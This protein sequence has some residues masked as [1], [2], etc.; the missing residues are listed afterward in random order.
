MADE[1]EWNAFADQAFIAT[2]D[3][4]LARTAAGAGV[5]VAGSH[6]VARRD[7]GAAYRADGEFR[8][9]GS[10]GVGTES[11][12]GKLHINNSGA[13][14]C[15]AIVG[16]SNGG[17]VVGVQADGTTDIGAFASRAMNF[18]HYNGGAWQENARFDSGGNFLPGADNAFKLG[19][20][21]RRF[22]TVY[23][24]T[25]SI[26]T[27]DER[28]KEEIGDIPDAWLD[29]WGDVAW[30]CFK[31]KGGWRWHVGLIAQRVHAAFKAHGLDAFEIGLC[32]F[33]QWDA[34]MRDIVDDDGEP[35]GK[36]EEIAAAGDRWGLRYDECF[37]MEAAWVRREMVRM[38][39]R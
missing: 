8:V 37:A 17:T 39:A 19:A 30:Q 18:G 11:P 22:S 5:E 28:E 25:G 35:T 15:Y 6:V 3:T 32:C 33:D 24:A 10:I 13:V 4:F 12:L 9:T 27:S 1:Q 36:Q 29:A 34:E 7:P 26:N 14:A 2:G 20:G 23:A 16:N 21:S 38:A 31:F